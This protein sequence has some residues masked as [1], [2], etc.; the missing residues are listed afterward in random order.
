METPTLPAAVTRAAQESDEA[1]AEYERQRQG[2]Q[3]TT[4][5]STLPAANEHAEYVEIPPDVAPKDHVSS[6]DPNA[7]TTQA[8]PTVEL[9]AQVTETVPRGEFDKVSQQYY[10]LQGQFRDRNAKITALEGEVARLTEAVGLGVQAPAANGPL[11]LLSEEEREGWEPESLD[12]QTRIAQGV[13]RSELDGALAPIMQRLSA[14]EG[15]TATMSKD[16]FWDRVEAA[17]PGSKRTDKEDTRWLFFLEH[18]VEPNTGQSYLELAKS[19]Q[20]DRAVDRMVR[21][22]RA[23]AEYIGVSRPRD[24]VSS[25]TKPVVARGGADNNGQPGRKRVIPI[26]E[27]QAFQVKVTKGHYADSPLERERIE[28]EY[29]EAEIDDRIDVSR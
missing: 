14:I 12:I 25:Q 28:A 8:A 4:P 20:S 18:Q 1:M 9:P 24:D 16:A 2:D 3:E 5:E 26:T 23:Y 27:I 15:S 10:S 13:F 22:L 19:A 29:R 11:E 21:I 7:Q 17:Y 6:G